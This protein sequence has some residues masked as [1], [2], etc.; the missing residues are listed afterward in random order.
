[1]KKEIKWQ[2]YV[3]LVTYL[4]IGFLHLGLWFKNPSV[5]DLK[6]FYIYIP[7]SILFY[8]LINSFVFIPLSRKIFKDDISRKT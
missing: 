3:M 8:S 1:M 2:L 7:L 6:L 4:N 5:I